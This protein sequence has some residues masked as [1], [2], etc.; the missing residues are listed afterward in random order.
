[1]AA[2]WLLIVAVSISFGLLHSVG[3]WLFQECTFGPSRMD[4]SGDHWQAAFSLTLSCLLA[5]NCAAASMA[6]LLP[7]YLESISPEAQ[8]ARP[9][10]YR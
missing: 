9:G 6:S 7:N 1:M 4:R 3:A 5:P 2:A 8:R 10:L